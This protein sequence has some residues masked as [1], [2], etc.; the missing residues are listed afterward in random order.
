MERIF[1]CIYDFREKLT[2]PSSWLFIFYPTNRLTFL[3]K[4][5]YFSETLI[6]VPSHKQPRA[7]AMYAQ[8]TQVNIENWKFRFGLIFSNLQGEHRHVWFLFGL[9]STLK[10]FTTHVFPISA[11]QN[12]INSHSLENKL[13][14]DEN[15]MTI[16]MDA[17]DHPDSRITWIGNCEAT[18]SLWLPA[19]A[20]YG[21]TEE[22][23]QM[24]NSS[25][26]PIFI[27]HTR[28]LN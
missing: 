14:C 25:S 11:V 5:N 10:L 17:L 3:K 28:N 12:Q 18:G 2:P 27:L 9:S 22:S 16:K 8:F 24:L 15:T 1:D 23:F 13:T 21:L 26:F 4:L 6:S 19:Q 20:N 7:R